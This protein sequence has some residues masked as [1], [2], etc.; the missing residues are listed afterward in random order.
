M[1]KKPLWRP[2]SVSCLNNYT[3]MNSKTDKEIQSFSSKTPNICLLQLFKNV[4]ILFNS[5]NKNVI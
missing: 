4:R 2:V 5:L 1:M 3:I